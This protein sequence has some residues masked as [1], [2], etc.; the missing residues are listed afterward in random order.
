LNN[1]GSNFGHHQSRRPEC[2]RE[3]V[4]S[5]STKSVHDNV[6]DIARTQLARSLEAWPPEQPSPG[7]RG[8]AKRSTKDRQGHTSSPSDHRRRDFSPL[9]SF[10]LFNQRLVPG[11]RSRSIITVPIKDRAPPRSH[12]VRPWALF[13]ASQPSSKW[14]IHRETRQDCDD[15]VAWLM[16]KA[17]GCGGDHPDAGLGWKGKALPTSPAHGQGSNGRRLHCRAFTGYRLRSRNQQ[18][19]A[20]NS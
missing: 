5:S 7:S 18:L 10:T 14:P 17:L 15:G 11:V 20:C 4:D 1:F 3:C 19:T 9:P 13:L 2:A 12:F 16:S 8:P 6:L